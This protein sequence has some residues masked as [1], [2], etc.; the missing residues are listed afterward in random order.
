MIHEVLDDLVCVWRGNRLRDR[1]GGARS[2][3]KVVTSGQISAV[4]QRVVI[5]VALGVIDS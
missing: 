1:V 2:E 5:E 3:D 4:I